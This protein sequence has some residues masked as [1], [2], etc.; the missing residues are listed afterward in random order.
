MP[1]DVSRPSTALHQ[2]CSS[3]ARRPPSLA[4]DCI[5]NMKPYIIGGIST[6]LK[7][8]IS[9]DWIIIPTR[10]GKINKMFHKP[11]T[12]HTYIMHHAHKKSMKYTSK[13]QATNVNKRHD[14]ARFRWKRSSLDSGGWNQNE[15]DMPVR[16]PFFF[17]SLQQTEAISIYIIYIWIF[18]IWTSWLLSLYRK[19]R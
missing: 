13:G 14:L 7:N 6:P 16:Q 2:G 5:V 1:C 17:R 18:I 15:S 11:P 8:M 19:K 3:K 10:K 4:E 12:S 9:S